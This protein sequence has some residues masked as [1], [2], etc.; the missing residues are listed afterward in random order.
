[1]TW[2]WGSLLALDQCS[3]MSSF[4]FAAWPKLATSSTTWD[5]LTQVFVWSLLALAEGKWPSRNF[6][7]SP[8]P[9]GSADADK[10]GKPLADGWRF[11][12]LALLGD[13]EHFSNN[14][15]MPRWQKIGSAGFVI[16]VKMGLSKSR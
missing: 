7:G 16:V 13:Q 9:P 10:A 6:D 2:S 8:W 1:M 15:G 5:P 12:V 11:V 3:L 14:L 4:L